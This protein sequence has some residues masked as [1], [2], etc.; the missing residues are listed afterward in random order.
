M[1]SLN[2]NLTMSQLELFNSKR[3]FIPEVHGQEKVMSSFRSNSVFV[4]VK[5]PQECS[6]RAKRCSIEAV[7]EAQV[8]ACEALP[9][10]LD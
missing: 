9:R 5:K 8:G 4:D 10:D 3:G 1:A 7:H 2:L 6:A